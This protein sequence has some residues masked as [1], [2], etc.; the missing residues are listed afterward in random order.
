MGENVQNDEEYCGN[1]KY[2][3]YSK[4]LSE[5]ICGRPGGE[6]DGIEMDYTEF[7]DEWEEK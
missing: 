6:Y 4:E 5:W 1:C 2:R 3:K 7:C